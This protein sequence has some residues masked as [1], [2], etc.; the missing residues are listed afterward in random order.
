MSRV[1]AHA[2]QNRDVCLSTHGHLPG[3]LRYMFLHISVP[4]VV[5]T[6]EVTVVVVTGV[7]V[8]L[9]S[10]GSGSHSSFSI[11]VD[12]LNPFSI[13]PHGQINVIVCPSSAGST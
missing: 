11:Q 7:P 6:T 2:G 4:I 9:T 5:V 1:S 3:T 8:H 12:E 10:L 13:S